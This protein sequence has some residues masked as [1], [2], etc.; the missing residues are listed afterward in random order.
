MIM[1]AIKDY[2]D[3]LIRRAG[4]GRLCTR[5]VRYLRLLFENLNYVCV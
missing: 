4:F 1:Y 3:L 2:I 5:C